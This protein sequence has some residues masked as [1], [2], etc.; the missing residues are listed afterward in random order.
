MTGTV[1]R[2]N[3]LA[4]RRAAPERPFK[5]LRA[6]DTHENSDTYSI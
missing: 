6:R 2:P 3:S 4:R 1:F 5:S